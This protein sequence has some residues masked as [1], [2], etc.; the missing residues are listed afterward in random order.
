MKTF[1]IHGAP[2]AGKT[3]YVEK[4]MGPNDIVFDFD[5]VMAAI[6]GLPV[7]GRNDT[8]AGY[9]LDIRDLIIARLKS[10]K[11]LDAAWIITT[12]VTEKFKQSLVGL[13]AE[14]IELKI[15]IHTA[16]QRLKESPRGRNVEEWSRA[17]DRYFAATADYSWF[18]KTK[19]WQRKRLVVLKRD[20]FRC[21]EAAR[22]GQVVEANTVHHCIPITERP[23]L[24][25][26]ERNLI[27]LSEEN[28]ERMH[29]KYTFELSKLGEE[30]KA[31]T[32]KRYPELS[33][34]RT[35]L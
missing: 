25:Q 35:I 33:V 11:N 26:D 22:F 9:V 13:N 17:I 12:R 6:S 3:T 31:R 20:E 2:L 10:E 23:D 16:R 7:H 34:V 14:Y 4:H 5:K 24:K 1:V 21:R 29:I 18:Y 27:S 30:W 28:H 8:L 32:L 15:D 19:R